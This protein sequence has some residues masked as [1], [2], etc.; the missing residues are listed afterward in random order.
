MRFR[1]RLFREYL[2]ASR[3]ARE[4]GNGAGD[5]AETVSRL[6][7]EGRFTD[8]LWQDVMVLLP[9]ALGDGR[10]GKLRAEV[11]KLAN[12]AGPRKGRLL[13]LAAAMVIET[14]RLYDGLDCA[15][16]A[17]V[18]AREYEREGSAWPL[19][20]RIDFLERLAWLDPQGGDPRLAEEGYR[21]VPIPGGEVTL[22]G[23]RRVKVDPFELAWAPVT[24][25]EYRAFVEAKDGLDPRWWRGKGWKTP[26]HERIRTHESDA[27][28]WQWQLSH[29][30]Q[31]VTWVS[32]YEAMACCAWRTAHRT[33]GRTI[34]LPTEAEWQ[35]AAAGPE[36]REHPW[37]HEDTGEGEAA[38]ANYLP[39]GVGEPT[40]VGAFPAGSWDEIV[41]LAGN[42]SEWCSSEIKGDPECRVLRGGSWD[43]TDR[44]YLRSASRTPGYPS[45]ARSTHYGLRSAS[46]A[47]TR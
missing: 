19:R 38:R 5:A 44:W 22:E 43:T 6:W 34:R 13:G 42:V 18:M 10:A 11:L 36:R 16:A 26:D 15:P 20:D 45:D 37:G 39:A 32:W 17:K 33:D 8:P 7:D 4:I 9:G 12:R 21:W 1:H 24:V 41:D 30:N 31:P 47:R 28:H 27:A 25:Q 23:G 2:A 40:P 35:W 14:R 29:P 3:L 46:A